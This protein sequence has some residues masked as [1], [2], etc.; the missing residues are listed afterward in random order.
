M[1]SIFRKMLAE[2]F[3][4]PSGKTENFK[5]IEII[6]KLINSKLLNIDIL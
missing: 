6:Q 3:A 1:S 4:K 5:W 2:N